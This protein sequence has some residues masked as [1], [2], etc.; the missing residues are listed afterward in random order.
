MKYLG[1]LDEKAEAE[2]EIGNQ[3]PSGMNIFI[4]ALNYVNYYFR[5]IWLDFR[6][7]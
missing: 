4:L 2:K 1:V 5:C 7:F 3:G 6:N